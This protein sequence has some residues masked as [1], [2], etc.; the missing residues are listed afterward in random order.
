MFDIAKLPKSIA[1]RI[2]SL[3]WR[4]DDMGCSGSTIL[5]FEKMALKIEK[6]GRAPENERK[7]LYWLDGK[8]P[9]PKV[10]EAEIQDGISYLLM[11]RLTGE[12]ACSG[13]S[14]R[15][16]GDTVRAL[17]NGLKML[18]RID[19]SNCP[20]S[21][22]VSEKLVQAK[23]RMENGLVD[24]NDFNPE[25]FTTEGFKDVPDLYDYLD[26]NR[27]REDF[28]FSH[29][30][31]CLPNVFVSGRGVTGFLDWGNGGIADR[32]QDIALCVR[33]LQYNY[34]EY[35][36]YGKEDYRKYKALLFEELGIE[37][38]EEKIRYYILLDELF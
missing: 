31:F 26:R 2:G 3:P 34:M 24:R 23:H 22:V 38:D 18:W 33:S 30:D 9:V 36:G 7:L 35:A 29:G 20:C 27:P 5:L 37:P 32:W 1:D 11:S 25:T 15:N 13:D 8:L 16:I 12:M 10:I 14:L 19:I 17:A 28:V 4:R 6:I 21:N